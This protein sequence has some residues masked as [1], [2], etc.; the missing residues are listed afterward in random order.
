MGRGPTTRRSYSGGIGSFELRTL[1]A[2]EPPLWS[3]RDPPILR[4][5]GSIY[6]IRDTTG[7]DLGTLQHP[8]PNLKAGDV[9]ILT[10]GREA[11]GTARVEVPA[12]GRR[13]RCSR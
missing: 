3:A 4:A 1:C 6:R 12:L 13:L 11:V 8:A 10:D 2:S 7:D 9:V 5:S